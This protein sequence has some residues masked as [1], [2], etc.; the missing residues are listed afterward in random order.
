MIVKSTFAVVNLSVTVDV[1]EFKV[2]GIRPE[3]G[4]VL[5]EFIGRPVVGLLIAEEVPVCPEA[6]DLAKFLALIVVE[7]VT[8]N[9]VVLL[10]PSA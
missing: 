3:V 4:S 8:I 2:S 10:H 6:P 5:V 1:D 7:D 9:V